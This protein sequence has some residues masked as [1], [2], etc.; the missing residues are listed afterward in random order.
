VP[1]A[2]SWTRKLS[3]TPLCAPGECNDDYMVNS[4][5][6]SNDGSV[7]VGGTYYQHYDGTTRKRVD[8]K[9]GL[10][11]F[12]T[13]GTGTKKF[14]DEYNGDKGI[15][16]VAIS[17]DGT[18][19]AGGGLLTKGKLSPFKPKRGLLRVFD[20]ATGT[21]L[22]DNADFPDRLNSLSLSR[23]GKVLA[24]VGETTLYVLLMNAAGVFAAPVQIDLDGYCETVSVHPG[25]GWLAAADQF[26]TVYVVTIT[27]AGIGSVTKWTALEPSNAMNPAS[28]KVPV[29]FHSVAVSRNSN[30][31]S[32]GGGDFV[33]LFKSTTLATGPVAKFC[34]FDVSGHHNVRCVATNDNGT[35][36]TAVVND[37]NLL[38]QGTGRLIK[39]SSTGGPLLNVDWIAPLRNLPN[40]TGI[41]SSGTKIV[42]SDGYPDKVPGTFY[43][44]DNNGTKLFEHITVKMNW[45]IAISA[46]GTRFV[47]GSD[48]NTLFFFKV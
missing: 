48:D 11:C 34:S 33:Y 32:A 45:P 40:T 39:L 6:I 38:G 28:F 29:K 4:A 37:Q 44:F 21:R 18:I 35:F 5:A 47:G 1:T 20:V 42:A 23:N 43:L 8:G 12:G 7:V 26:G 17:G 10:Y 25:G 19:A 36:V 16:T 27:A 24:A 13:A 15:Y 31:L 22:L 41:D 14:D 30:F 3:A 9:F 46:N 2:L